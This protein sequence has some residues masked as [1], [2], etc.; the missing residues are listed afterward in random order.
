MNKYEREVLFKR[1]ADK[2]KAQREEFSM[3]AE[4]ALFRARKEKAEKEKQVKEAK[5]QH[6]CRLISQIL[7]GNLLSC[8]HAHRHHLNVQCL[9]LLDLDNVL[10]LS[11]LKL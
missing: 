6:Q 2:E 9:Q 10:L 8:R 4:E 3:K 1:I 7:L 5:G 11:V